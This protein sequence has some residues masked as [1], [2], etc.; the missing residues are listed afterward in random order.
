MQLPKQP[1]IETER[2]VL[3]LVRKDDLPDLFVVNSDSKVFRYTPRVSW[4]TPADGRAWFSRIMAHRKNGATIQ[5]V[6]VLRESDHPIGT[7]A[8]FNFDESVG[9]AEIGY[10]LGRKHWGKGLIKEALAAFVPF[11]FETLKLN[12]L[13]AELDPRNEASAKALERIGFTHE[14]IRRSNYFSKGEIT[15]TGL[16]GMLSGDPRPAAQSVGANKKRMSSNG[17]KGRRPRLV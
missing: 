2:L 13:E 1:I 3:R 17:L 16:Y 6:V 7:F 12:R 5:F 11:A 14:G 9:S 10:V 8:V 15:D 4:K